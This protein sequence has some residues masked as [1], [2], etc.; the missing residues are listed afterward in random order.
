MGIPSLG[1]RPE[2]EPAR[3]AQEA[4]PSP[5]PGTGEAVLPG[6]IPS[7]SSGRPIGGRALFPTGPGRLYREAAW[8]V[9]H[10]P[11]NSSVTGQLQ[12]L[13]TLPV[14]YVSCKRFLIS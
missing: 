1:Q 6:V 8:G 7:V 5:S 14:S 9:H 12:Q 3:M 13:R 4:A 2:E 11:W 10:G